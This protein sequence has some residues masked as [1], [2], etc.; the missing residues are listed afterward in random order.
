VSASLRA[1]RALVIVAA[2]GLSACSWFTDFK[3]QPK[4][5][6]WESPSDS[7][8]PRANP[9]GSV[10]ITG[11]AAPDFMYSHAG[12]AAAMQNNEAMSSIA[13]PVPADS[14]SVVRGQRL[15]QINCA[16]CHGSAG[17]GGGMIFKYTSP[18]G[19]MVG[20]ALGANSRPATYTDGKIFGIIRNGQGQ[21]PSYPRIEESERWDIVNYMRALQGKGIVAADTSHGR[22]G[23]TG[24]LVPGS[25][26]T[27]PTRPAPYFRVALPAA[28][29]ATK[30]AT[31]PPVHPPDTTKG[32]R[33]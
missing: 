6:P 28:P 5:D 33:S 16:V 13:N 23:E 20:A 21:M 14:A 19:M 18:P 22:P 4:I 9:Q 24:H 2:L 7:I 3:Q 29:P 8:P 27:A 10:P 15:F 26:R 32:V 30:A 11:L 1:Q 31:P 17:Q 12:G 25:T